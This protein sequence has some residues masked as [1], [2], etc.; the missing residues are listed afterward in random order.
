M[1]HVTKNCKYFN[2]FMLIIKYSH[3]MR[4]NYVRYGM[5]IKICI[6]DKIWNLTELPN[7]AILSYMHFIINL[8][9]NSIM[10]IIY[11]DI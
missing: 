1:L 7:C 10:C 5:A 6:F 9:R 2:L 4:Q 11:Q 8:I 3:V